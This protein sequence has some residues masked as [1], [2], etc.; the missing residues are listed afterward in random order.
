[1]IHV[2]GKSSWPSRI[3]LETALRE[4]LP[5]LEGTLVYG[6]SPCDKLVALQRCQEA[7]ILVPEVLLTP[8]LTQIGQGEE[9]WRRKL[10]HSQGRD[11][12]TNP[13]T[14][15]WIRGDYWVKRIPN[16]LLEF[17]VHVVR[18][19]AFRTGVKFPP[20]GIPDPT[21]IRSS[22]RGWNLCYSQTRMDTVSTLEQREGIREIAVRAV[23]AVGVPTDQF[24]AV[25]LLLTQG[26]G[27]YVLEVNTAPALGPET[28][29]SYV[30]QVKKIWKNRAKV[31]EDV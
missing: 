8:P 13:L 30:E 17:R 2:S 26:G 15:R 18:G 12:E 10:H 24:S 29:S 9:W 19:R 11:I 21:P 23:E 25:D 22:V 27:V 28:L 7:G 1:M 20:E 31:R 14:H 16:V 4:N 3:L 6:H 5:L